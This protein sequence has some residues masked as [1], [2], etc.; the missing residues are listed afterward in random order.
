MKAAHTEIILRL[1][2]LGMTVAASPCRHCNNKKTTVSTVA[3]ISVVMTV[4]FPQDRET[5]PHCSARN[6]QVK[7]PH[8]SLWVSYLPALGAD[9]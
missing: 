1:S 2:I 8:A 5:P 4:A 3:I 6:R 7:K 9:I